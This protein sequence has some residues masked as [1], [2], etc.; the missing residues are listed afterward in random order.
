MIKLAQAVSV[1]REVLMQHLRYMPSSVLVVLERQ[2]YDLYVHVQSY[3]RARS[4]QEEWMQRQ[5]RAQRWMSPPPNQRQ[6]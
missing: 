6:N 4:V 2:I 1:L 5:I 3:R